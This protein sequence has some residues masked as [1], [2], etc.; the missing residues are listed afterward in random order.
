LRADL[1]ISKK[2]AEDYQLKA[3]QAKVKKIIQERKRKRE[4][5]EEG[6]TTPE[7]KKN[8]MKLL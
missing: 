1:S 7:P 5:K 4:S 2:A 3:E 6:P 8:N